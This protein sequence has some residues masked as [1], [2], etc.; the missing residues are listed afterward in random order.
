MSGPSKPRLALLALLLAAVSLA[1]WLGS[2]RLHIETDVTT[3]LPQ[4]DKIMDAA[5]DILHHNA[6]LE[7]MIVDLSF[8][9][10]NPDINSLV[11][12]AGEIEQ[13]LLKS[14]LIIKSETAQ[15]TEAMAWLLPQ[16]TNH[17]PLFF[18]ARELTDEVS[19]RLKSERIKSALTQAQARLA[20]LGG[21]GQA[22][23][24]AKDPL[25]LTGLVMK[26]LALANPL[27]GASV[28]QGFLISP[29]RKHLLMVLKPKAP[30]GDTRAALELNR[31]MQN[32]QIELASRR[33]KGAV[34]VK[35]TYA[36]AFRAAL[37]N[38]T[39]IRRD[40]NRALLIVSIGLLIL[41]L[42]CFRRPWIG[43]LALV[44]AVAGVLLATFVYSIFQN[45][46]MAL[47]MGFGGALIAVA[48]D[49]GLAYVLLL[50]RGT[51]T[52]GKIVSH[53]LWK[54]ASFPVFT[55]VAAL[56]ALSFSGVP[57]FSEVGLFAAFGVGLAALFVH[58]FFPLAFPRLKGSP[59][60]AWL[61]V[62]RFMDRIVQLAGWKTMGVAI[63]VAVILACFVRFDFK[64]DLN[65]MNTV[66]P[67]TSQ[68]ERAVS[69]TWGNMFERVYVM[70][71][72]ANQNELWDKANKLG[73]FLTTQ[74][75]AG[76]VTGS[77][78]LMTV[79]PGPQQQADNL[80][81]WKAF[82]TPA[83]VNALRANMSQVASETGFTPNAFDG[84]VRMASAPSVNSFK[85]LPS[86]FS[87]L[88]ITP[89]GDDKG[90]WFM[91][92]GVARGAGYQAPPFIHQAEAAGFS[93]FDAKFFSTHI[94][95][96]LAW[97]FVWMLALIVCGV[98]V[99]LVFLFLDTALVFIALAPL[100][101]ALIATLG[102]LGALGQPLSLSSLMLAPVV[103]GMGLDYG[104]YLVRSHQ[105]YGSASAA[106][107]GPFR[108]TV[109]L[110]GVSTLM[111]MGALVFSEHAVLREAGVTTSLGILF[112]LLG[113]FCLVP[114]MLR[115][116]FRQTHAA[117][118][119]AVIDSRDHLGKALLRFRHLEPHPRLFARF[120]IACDPMFPRLAELVAGRT[121]LDVGC[122]YAVPAAWLLSINPELYFHSM[123][124]DPERARVAARVLGSN[125]EVHQA[126]APNLASLPSDADTALALDM[127]HYL[128]DN[129]FATMLASLNARLNPRGHLV[130]RIT[131]P[132]PQSFSWLRWFELKRMRLAGCKPYFRSREEISRM[133][134]DAGFDLQICEPCAPGREEIWFVC[135]SKMTD[136]EASA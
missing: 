51:T 126:A 122:G 26:K 98:V 32:L 55:T 14:G 83:R 87:F 48:V 45:T 19:P 9:N 57:L 46:I 94:A 61:P 62:G 111:G 77:F 37:D 43:V 16:I 109:L 74:K 10:D 120:K 101:F 112:A 76:Q 4:N 79:L 100:I 125:G 36:G 56:L 127:A 8:G 80:A 91:V 84:F 64:A 116:V 35:L 58:L 130:M 85:L 68:A 27:P 53:E 28:Q 52:E 110:G 129:E 133:L 72:G 21:I 73:S 39:I 5:R 63:A 136:I 40:T 81:D 18:N 29:D 106:Q 93:V 114:P 90:S 66:T 92:D 121:I 128:D 118:T 24:L 67:A 119:P 25:G 132:D 88:G 12:A 11:E 47:A 33:D 3:A 44:P 131:I 97:S 105:R 31:F 117:T 59:R 134:D 30:S 71:R 135:I 78:P 75:N 22:R 65:A 107:T 7:S 124:P 102:T 70:V 50:D 96:A 54:I 38:E 17:L 95:Q 41:V 86:L 49:H 20:E 99:L 1:F 15:A 60:K 103:L 104:L 108:T 82:W 115:R 69:A 89:A 42:C 113:A 23:L 123:E 34:P 2:Q 6:N 13:K